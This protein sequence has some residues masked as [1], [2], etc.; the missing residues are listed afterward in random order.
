MASEIEFQINS[1]LITQDTD[2]LKKRLVPVLL[3]ISGGVETFSVKVALSAAQIKTA[4]SVPIDVG[5][6]ASGAGYYWR[7]LAFDNNMTYGTEPF[8][9]TALTLGATTA[10]LD[11]GQLINSAVSNSASVFTNGVYAGGNGIAENDTL[12]ISASTDSATG[13]STIDCYLTVQKVSL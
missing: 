4:N 3:L 10:N 8:T 5:L 6:P 13:D 12:S 2:Q 11:E 9:T 7:V 1:L